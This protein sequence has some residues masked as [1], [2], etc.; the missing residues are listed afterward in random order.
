MPA[1]QPTSIFHFTPVGN[2]ERLGR[3]NALLSKTRLARAALQHENASYAQIQQRRALKAVPVPPGG[4]LH[5]YVPFYFAPRSPMLLT[6]NSGN[7]PGVDL[8]QEDF[9]YLVSTAQRIS[10]RQPFAFTNMHAVLDLAEFFDDLANLDRVCWDL[11]MEVP[12]IS[13]G[14]CRFWQNRNDPLRYVRR[15]EAR[16]AEFLAYDSVNLADITQIVVM[17]EAAKTKA[18]QGLAASGWDVSVSVVRDWYY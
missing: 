1:P 9:A 14:Y 13:G 7:V 12:H 4:V 2:L 17:T 8:R 6:I 11:I 15:M 5:D 18:E 3:A 10:A 16:Q